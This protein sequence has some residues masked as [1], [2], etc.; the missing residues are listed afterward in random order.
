MPTTSRRDACSQVW[1]D[2]ERAR[3]EAGI[4]AVI[5]QRFLPFKF[6]ISGGKSACVWYSSCAILS[7][8]QLILVVCLSWPSATNTP[9]VLAMCFRILNARLDGATQDGVVR[10][11]SVSADLRWFSSLRTS[12]RTVKRKYSGTF[13]PQGERYGIWL[14]K[15]TRG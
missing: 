3:Y 4:R 12:R 2:D 13:P 15:H 7:F 11:R 10:R 5:P 14:R 9:F 8:R 1:N 6:Y